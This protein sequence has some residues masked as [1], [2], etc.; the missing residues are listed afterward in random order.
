MMLMDVI[1]EDEQNKWMAKVK[2]LL[3]NLKDIGCTR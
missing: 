3:L 1:N 2:Q